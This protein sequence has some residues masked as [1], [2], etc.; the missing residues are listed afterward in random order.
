MNLNEDLKAIVFAV[1]NPC[2]PDGASRMTLI[3]VFAMSQELFEIGQS[4]R[5]SRSSTRLDA[6]RVSSLPRT[7]R[8]S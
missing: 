7:C 1:L 8:I 3:N 4:M 5:W 6:K 2:R